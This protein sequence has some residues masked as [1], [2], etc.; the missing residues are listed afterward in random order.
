MSEITP[1]KK[2]QRSILVGIISNFFLAIIKLTTGILGHSFA[3]VA[4]GIESSMDVFSSIVIWIG[5]KISSI[6]ADQNHPYGHGKAESLS[7]IVVSIFLLAA[8]VIIGAESIQKFNTDYQ[9]PAPYTLII[10]AAVIFTKEFLFRYIFKV[11]DHIDSIALKVDAWHHR[12][13]AITSGAA[14]IGISIALIGGNEYAYADV[15]AALVAACFIAFNGWKLLSASVL[16]IMDGAPKPHLIDQVSE[17]VL[18]VKDV[19]Q[20]SNCLVRKSGIGYFVDVHVS[21]DGNLT[22]FQSHEIDHEIKHI[23]KSST[24]L[25]EKVMVHIEPYITTSQTS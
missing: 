3:L 7:A 13:D 23:L 14:F 18:N 10:L 5:L 4:D 16:E 8:A 15:W 22:V 12:S 21:I 20:V 1:Y 19:R 6:P 9:S 2:G 17:L 25:V 24:L 11:S